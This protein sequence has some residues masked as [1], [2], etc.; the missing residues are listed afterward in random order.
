MSRSIL[1]GVCVGSLV[2]CG[3]SK[4]DAPP[5][6]QTVTNELEPIPSAALPEATSSAPPAESSLAL[7]RGTFSLEAE[8]MTFQLCGEQTTLWVIDESDGVLRETFASEPKPLQLYVEAHGERAAVPA[9]ISAARGF[10]GVFILEEVLYATLPSESQG[11]NSPA[12]DYI[13]MAR[14]NE[15]FWSV[16]VTADKLLWRQPDAPKEVVFDAAQ[17]QDAEGTVGY[18]GSAGGHTI[19]LLINAQVCRDSMSGALFAYTARATFD[20]NQLKGCA[21]IGE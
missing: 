3:C 10:P 2:L 15:P 21:R 7:K 9:E 6:S 12:P 16:D 19:E 18:T 13:V 1:L 17:S 5:D 14:G 8:R 20:G 11:C 4:Q